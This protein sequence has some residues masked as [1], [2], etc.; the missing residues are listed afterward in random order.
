MERI[1]E[2]ND[3]DYSVVRQ[4]GLLLWVVP[5]L[6]CLAGAVTGTVVFARS[7]TDADV[8]A[9][10]LSQRGLPIAFGGYFLYGLLGAVPYFAAIARGKPP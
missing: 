1:R 3:F 7:Y 10:V 6:L 8:T 5:A 2:Q 9:F 4:R